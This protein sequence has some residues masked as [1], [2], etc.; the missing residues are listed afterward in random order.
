MSQAGIDLFLVPAAQKPE[1]IE[2]ARVAA[3]DLEIVTV[4]SLDEAIDALVG[5][6]GTRPE[7]LVTR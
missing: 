7:P 3:P 5:A 1:D 6:G 2:A 4:A